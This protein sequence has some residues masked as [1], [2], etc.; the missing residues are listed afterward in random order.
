VSHPHPEL[1]APP[2]LPAHGLRVVALGGLGEVGRNMTVLEYG[3]RLLVIDCG[4]LFPEDFQPGVDLILP[5]FD[6]I[7]DRL[8]QVEGVVLTHGHE[9]HI[10]AVPYLLREKP[11]I[12]LLGSRLTLALVE[13]KLQEHRIKPYTLE[14]REGQRERLGPSTASSSR[15]TT[16]SRTRSPWPCAPRPAPCCTPAT[17]SWTSCR[18][19]VA[20]PTCAPSPAS[21]RRASTSSSSTRPTRRFPASPP[22]SGTSLR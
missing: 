6:S 7:R 8:D 3:G 10:G 5:D 22:P 19:T 11:D 20:S 17:S 16:R 1:E 2:E 15:S 14:V 4:V 13:A 21:G 9:D 12:P 18:S